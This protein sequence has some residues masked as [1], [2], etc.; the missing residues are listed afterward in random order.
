MISFGL[1]LK[2][3]AESSCERRRFYSLSIL[4]NQI[5]ALGFELQLCPIKHPEVHHHRPACKQVGQLTASILTIGK[6]RGLQPIYL[7]HVAHNQPSS[8]G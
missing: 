6:A 1:Y 8:N 7:D 5:Q 3:V 4:I 2:M